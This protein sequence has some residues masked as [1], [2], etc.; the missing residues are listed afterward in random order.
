MNWGKSNR[1]EF[2]DWTITLAG[3]IANQTCRYFNMHAR[4]FQEEIYI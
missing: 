1:Y 4:F 3:V 2:V